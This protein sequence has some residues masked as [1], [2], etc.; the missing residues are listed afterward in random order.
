MLLFED[1]MIARDSIPKF[2]RRVGRIWLLFIDLGRF[3]LS[4]S[5]G[6]LANVTIWVRR[7]M[8]EDVMLI[9]AGP[10]PELFA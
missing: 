8:R 10:L 4:G 7:V 5:L 1:L 9:A 3:R 6:P 2:R